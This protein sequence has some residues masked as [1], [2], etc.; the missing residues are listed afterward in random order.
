MNRSLTLF[1]KKRCYLFSKNN[2]KLMSTID[3]KSYIRIYVF[4]HKFSDLEQKYFQ[5]ESDYQSLHKKYNALEYRLELTEMNQQ[6][7]ERRFRL[8]NG[9]N[10]A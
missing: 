4:E 2:K 10:F 8:L 3:N 1:S 9:D 5:L 6:L 7:N